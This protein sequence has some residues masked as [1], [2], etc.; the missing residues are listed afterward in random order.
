MIEDL[1]FVS[2]D[3][4]ETDMDI[5]RCEYIEVLGEG[6]VVDYDKTLGKDL[7][8]SVGLNGI[9]KSPWM[10]NVEFP[11]VSNGNWGLNVKPR[12]STDGSDGKVY[13]YPDH[14]IPAHFR[15]DNGGAYWNGQKIDVS[16]WGAN[17]TNFQSVLDKLT[18]ANTLYIGSI[19]GQHRSRAIYRFIRVVRNG[20]DSSITGGDSN[21]KDNPGY[22]G[23]L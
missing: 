12:W 18:A 5:H 6:D 14:T 23:Q 22:G 3:F 11:A 20:R 17:Q 4:I 2:G 19:E 9:D 1:D 7:L 21:F 15:L 8:F 10:L 16:K 13:C